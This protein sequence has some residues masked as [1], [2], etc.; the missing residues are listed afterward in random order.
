M[1]IAFLDLDH[2][3]LAADSNQLWM[4]FLCSHDMVSAQDLSIHDQ[5]MIDYANGTLDFGAL[6][7]FRCR[8][9]A[10]LPSEFLFSQR[11]L[12]EREILFPALAPRA[13]QLLADLRDMGLSLVL[14]SATGRSLV[15]PV[16]HCLGIDH[17]ICPC[18]GPDKVDH[19]QA[20]LLDRCCSLESL[21]ESWFFT[22]SHNDLPLLER[23]ANP[24]VVDPDPSLKRVAM[25]RGWRAISLCN[26]D[27][28]GPFNLHG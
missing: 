14:V 18:F 5:F 6:S 11:T 7:R 2:T 1:R 28:E 26:V 8:I 24:V 22:D 13:I 25:D 4:S 3:L 9:E 12:F 16:A 20:W 19:V 10:D 21:Q 23:V 27:C 17:V 15:D